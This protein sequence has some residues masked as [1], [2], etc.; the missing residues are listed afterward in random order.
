MVYGPYIYINSLAS[1]CEAGQWTC[2]SAACG[3]RCGAVGDP[4]YTTFDGLRYDFMGHCTYTM[5]KTDN[6][7][8]DV[9]NVACSG[10]ITE[11][12]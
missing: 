1:T 8:I 2:T 9:E 7:T 3:A 5:L 6:L 10:A 4:H 12:N 11:V